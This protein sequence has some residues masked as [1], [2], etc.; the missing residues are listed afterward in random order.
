MD[1][2][3]QYEDVALSNF[4]LIKLLDGKANIVIYPNL[5]NYNNIDE[6]LGPYGACF[7]L[8]E[9]KKQYGH[10]VCLFKR[11]QNTI[12][13]FNSYGGYPDTSL[14]YIPM[15]FREESGQIYPYL[16]WL[17]LESPYELEYNEFQFQKKNKNIKTCGRHTVIR[18]LL[19]DLD[20]YQ[21]KA[22]LDMIKRKTGMNYDQIVTMLTIKK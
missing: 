13:F 17:L 22:F 1:I 9:S 3:K 16:S 11:N 19:R 21:Y 2:I 14:E 4:D 8:F 18:L 6:V 5:V 12:E 20:I 15:H 7:L 10:W